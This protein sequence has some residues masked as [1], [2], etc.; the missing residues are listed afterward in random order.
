MQG[1]NKNVDEIRAH[2]FQVLSRNLAK[3]GLPTNEVNDLKER[4]ANSGS[5]AGGLI[6]IDLSDG[7]DMDC[8]GET[9]DESVKLNF[10]FTKPEQIL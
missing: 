7:S 2:F 8:D 9:G 3:H 4:L 1:L 6:E 10:F 5:D